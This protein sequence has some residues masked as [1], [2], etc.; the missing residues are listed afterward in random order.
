VNIF[1]F[2][3]L[4][5]SNAV[6]LMA[7]PIVDKALQESLMDSRSDSDIT[8]ILRFK[9]SGKSL[10]QYAGMSPSAVQKQ[11]MKIAN[12][13]QQALLK[14]FQ[15]LTEKGAPLKRALTLW[16]NNA[17]I[18]TASKTFIQSLTRRKDIKRMELDS[19]IRIFDPIKRIAEKLLDSPDLTYG[20]SKIRADKV[21]S[22]LGINGD[23]VVVGILD[24]GVDLRHPALQGKVIKTRDFISE[25]EDDQ[26][27]DGNG[28]G[29]HCSGTILG[30]TSDGRQI[31]VAPGAKLI[32]GKIFGDK[33]ATTVAAI[34]E[35]MQWMADPDG[36][37]DTVDFPRVVSNSW[38]ARFNDGWQEITDTWVSLGI[39]PVFAAGNSGQ[40]RKAIN[41]PGGYPEVIAVGATDARDEI[42]SFSSRGPVDY[43]GQTYPKPD[44]TAPG[45]DIFSAKPGQ[46]NQ[47]MSGT[48]MATPH[49]AGVVALMLQAEPDLSLGRVKEILEESAVE[50]GELGKDNEY[51]SGRVDAYQAVQ[52]ILTGG[53]ARLHIDSGHQ[54]ATIKISQGNRVYRTNASGQALISLP[55]GKY[56]VTLTAFGY[57]EKTLNLEIQA[58][59]TIAINTVLKKAPHYTVSFVARDQHGVAHE[60]RISFLNA[61]LSAGETQGG[62]LETKLP[63]G[64]YTVQVRGL[65]FKPQKVSFSVE[66]DMQVPIHLKAVPPFLIVDHD[67]NNTHENYYIAS[68]E[69]NSK[70]FHVTKYISEDLISGFRYVVWFS[71]RNS[72]GSEIMNGSEQEIVQNYIL[73]GGR[74]I[75]SGQDVGFGLRFSSFYSRVLGAR[76]LKDISPVKTI[77]GQGLNFQLGGGDSANN[78]RWPD[79]IEIDADTGSSVEV[80]FTYQGQ[81]P[82]GLLNTYGKGKVAYLAFGFEGI[83]TSDQ[84]DK[85]MKIL[86]EAVKPTTS[87]ALDRIQWA[88][89]KNKHAYHALSEGIEITDENREGILRYLMKTR[90]KRAFRPLLK[91]LLK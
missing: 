43:L 49:V 44:V 33:G 47:L 22:D 82:A 65:G 89:E 75:L 12:A 59:Q 26:P 80:L 50:L 29:T 91:Q 37:P 60:A 42:A 63:V 57:F 35:A 88:F 18:L 28:H 51:G 76:Y 19:E 79:V 2:L 30:G 32:M 61:P 71:G 74:L 9:T 10:S 73:H 85:V 64:N 31:G 87:E 58:K 8:V 27:N 7:A 52:M 90:D 13:A 55:A 16:V 21:W 14:E 77:Q 46:A 20:L 39:I 53:K 62:V 25:Y 48:S 81:G 84:R 72:Q 34:M 70:D 66:S 54:I 4:T 36:N 24:S 68:L 6:F 15:V 23:G 40:R 86:I 56:E 17:M 67:Q 78:Q 41:A 11:K 3:I 1:W 45:V 83:P 5:F 38:G 69:A